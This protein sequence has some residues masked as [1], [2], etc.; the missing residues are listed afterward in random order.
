MQLRQMDCDVC[1][2]YY[3]ISILRYSAASESAMGFQGVVGSLQGICKFESKDNS[4]AD[5]G[6]KQQ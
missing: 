5:N 3:V 2:N 1:K 4:D 6:V